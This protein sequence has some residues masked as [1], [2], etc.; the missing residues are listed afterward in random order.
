MNYKIKEYRIKAGLT[1]KELS[2][3]SGVN[4]TTIS[5]L[6]SGNEVNVSVKVLKKI[7]ECLGINVNDVFC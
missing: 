1:Q 6:E 2:A 7:A 4:R 5:A 3:E